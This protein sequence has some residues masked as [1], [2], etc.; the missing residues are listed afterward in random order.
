[1]ALGLTRALVGYG[2]WWELRALIP[3]LTTKYFTLCLDCDKQVLVILLLGAFLVKGDV[4][5][6]RPGD[7]V[8]Y[9]YKLSTCWH[10]K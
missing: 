9:H 5:E 1:M 7:P 3:Q 4:G 2:S 6:V 8:Q 10:C